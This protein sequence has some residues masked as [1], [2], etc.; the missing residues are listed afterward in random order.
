MP[1]IIGAL[2][3][4]TAMGELVN[5]LTSELTIDHRSVRSFAAVVLVAGCLWP[6]RRGPNY[7]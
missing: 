3:T 5:Q 7:F 6:R 4:T 2:T 1:P